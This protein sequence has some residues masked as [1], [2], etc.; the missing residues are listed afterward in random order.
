MYESTGQ[1]LVPIDLGTIIV[2]AVVAV[3][4]VPL[5][6]PANNAR[7]MLVTMSMTMP[8]RVLILLC[9]LPKQML[10]ASHNVRQKEE[11]IEPT[12]P[13]SLALELS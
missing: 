7:G 1:I 8:L 2:S 5:E 6:L 10:R 13:L 12:I 11:R 3:E 4:K 9:V